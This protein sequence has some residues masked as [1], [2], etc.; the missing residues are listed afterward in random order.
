MIL[1][2]PTPIASDETYGELSLRLS[3]LG[4]QALIE[5]LALIEIGAARETPQDDALAT[6]APKPGPGAVTVD[7]ARPAAE[8]SQMIRSVDPRPGAVTTAAA[9][10][11]KLFG[12][13]LLPGSGAME[14]GPVAPAPMAPYS[15]STTTEWPWPAGAGQS[16]S[17]RCSLRGARS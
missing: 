1:R 15:P 9:G 12:A 7:W 16:A 2:I 5:T 11:V 14:S 3:E 6:Y 17:P 13:Q 8:I 4:A 10:P